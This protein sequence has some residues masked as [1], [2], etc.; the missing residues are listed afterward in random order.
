MVVH[1]LSACRHKVVAAHNPLVVAVKKIECI[2]K[3]KATGFMQVLLYI[4][5]CSC[6]KLYSQHVHRETNQSFSPQEDKRRG[7]GKD[8]CPLLVI[9]LL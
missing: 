3:G 5:L 1:C 6:E 4:F 7:R 2:F 9:I 8:E